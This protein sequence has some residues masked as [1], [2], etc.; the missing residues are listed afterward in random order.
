MTL[1]LGM[2]SSLKDPDDPFEFSNTIP[3][4]GN[5]ACGVF[6]VNL[7]DHAWILGLVDAISSDPERGA[8]LA[9]PSSVALAFVCVAGQAGLHCAVPLAAAMVIG[10]GGEA[11]Q[12]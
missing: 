10:M 1:L 12:G 8:S 3:Q 11:G 2:G 6:E 7:F 4:T 9:R 5:L